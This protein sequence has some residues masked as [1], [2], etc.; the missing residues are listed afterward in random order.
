MII[1]PIKNINETAQVIQSLTVVMLSRLE[2]V[3]LLNFLYL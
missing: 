1:N 3:C 2:M